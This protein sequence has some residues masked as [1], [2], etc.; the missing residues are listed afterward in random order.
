MHLCA[1]NKLDAPQT[2]RMQQAELKI[3]NVRS[4]TT[5]VNAALQLVNAHGLLESAT[6]FISRFEMT[7]SSAFVNAARTFVN[8]QEK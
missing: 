1:A 5:I 6:C 3:N 2:Y 7:V 8:A 4:I